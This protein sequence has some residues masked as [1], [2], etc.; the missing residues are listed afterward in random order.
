MTK[1]YGF[2]KMNEKLIEDVELLRSKRVIKKD[3]EIARATDFDK[4]V[5]S[6][7]LSGRVNA[8]KNF[9][10]KFYQVYSKH[11]DEN[12]VAESE[13]TYD[14]KGN[15]IFVPLVAYGGFLTGYANKVFTDE[16]QRFSLPGIRGEHYAFEVDGMS[17]YDFAAPKDWAIAKELDKSDILLKNKAYVLQTTDGILIKYFDKKDDQKGTFRSHNAEYEP[18]TIP[19]KSIKKVYFVTRIIKNVG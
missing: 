16:L 10:D 13:V 17:M 5:I 7:Y 1:T 6:N 12:K 14:K 3:V 11:L 18:I 2:F 19:L 15:I 9:L 4:T 8:S